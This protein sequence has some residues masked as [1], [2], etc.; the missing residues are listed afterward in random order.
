MSDFF[1]KGPSPASPSSPSHAREPQRPSNS[2]REDPASRALFFF[3]LPA[4]D[5]R[6]PHVSDAV[7]SAR[8]H[9]FFFLPSP[10][11]ALR[12]GRNPPRFPAINTSIP[13]HSL[14][15]KCPMTPSPFPLLQFLLQATRP[16]ARELAVLHFGRLISTTPVSLVDSKPSYLAHYSCL[17]P[18][19]ALIIFV[20]VVLCSR[21]T[22][23][24]PTRSSAADLLRRSIPAGQDTPSLLRPSLRHRLGLA[25]LVVRPFSPPAEVRQ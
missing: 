15:Y 7:T 20:V 4:V 13:F 10:N 24:G 8:R 2:A 11:R 18:T 9:T 12:T 21:T 1:L 3:S 14:F 5:R 6:D 19:H 16:L 23:R 25:H 22:G 17:A